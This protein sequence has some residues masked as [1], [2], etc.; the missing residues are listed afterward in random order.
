MDQYVDHIVEP[1]RLLLAWQ[2]PDHMGN[3]RRWVVGH[4][5][6][7]STPWQMSY[8]KGEG[9]EKANLHA[10]YSTI[11]ALGYEGY[12]A[13]PLRG[14]AGPFK[15]S[16]RETFMRRLPPRSRADFPAY[17]ARFGF[18]N[19]DGLS[20][21]ALLAY[22]EAKLPS[23][24]FSLVGELEPTTTT[25]DLIF[26][27]A[28]TRHQSSGDSCP[29][30]A[31]DFL[32]LRKEPTNEFDPYAIEVLWDD[33]R[34]GYVNRLQAK[35]VGYWMDHRSVSVRVQ[36]VNGRSGHP[37]VYALMQIRPLSGSVAA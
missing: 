10:T 26:D 8:L 29:A 11:I 2:A 18:R 23:D 1:K 25:G 16:V 30:K 27:V 24:G 35:T 12:P 14:S 33:V 32:A 28:G 4:V 7:G 34:I 13:F 9:F 37:K 21:A 31:G 19:A 17:I 20:D 36:R 3:R 22:T 6:V 5:D 15:E